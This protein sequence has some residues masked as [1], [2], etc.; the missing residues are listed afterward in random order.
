MC[1]ANTT[2]VHLSGILTKPSY[3]RNG[4]AC[5]IIKLDM[6]YYNALSLSLAL[7]RQRHPKRAFLTNRF[8]LNFRLLSL[9]C[10]AH[11]KPCNYDVDFIK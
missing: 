1:I 2:F 10:H 3:E 7:A 6:R 5:V 9:Y 4:N 11:F 8:A